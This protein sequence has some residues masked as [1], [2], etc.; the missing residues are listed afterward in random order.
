[1]RKSILLSTP[2]ILISYRFHPFSSFSF[3]AQQVITSKTATY[4]LWPF[5]CF[6]IPTYLDF[7]QRPNI[8]LLC[9]CE[10]VSYAKKDDST[11]DQDNII[12]GH[13]SSWRCR[14]PE[15]EEDSDDH[16]CA[17]SHVNRDARNPW[18]SERTTVQ[19][20]FPGCVARPP[21]DTACAAALEKKY[22][23]DEV[24]RV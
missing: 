18:D 5:Q 1:M 7:D 24:R 10:I 21:T 22:V 19:T 17:G 9:D 14:L 20:R 3:Q 12:H 16:I 8:G 4:F 15:T 13:R 23:V 6:C 2:T 11:K